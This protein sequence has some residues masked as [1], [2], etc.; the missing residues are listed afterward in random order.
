VEKII[1]EAC[2]K[3][4]IDHNRDVADNQHAYQSPET[5]NEGRDDARKINP[6]FSH[7]EVSFRT[8]RSRNSITSPLDYGS[9]SS[10][11]EAHENPKHSS[12]MRSFSE[13]VGTSH[14]GLKPVSGN[15]VPF[16]LLSTSVK[17]TL[18]GDSEPSAS[19][20]LS[21][22]TSNAA[23]DHSRFPEFV[24]LDCSFVTGFDANASV[25]LFKLRNK[26]ANQELG[27]SVP[28]PI[29]LFFAGE[30]LIY[31]VFIL[32]VLFPTY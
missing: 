3:A 13:A 21:R 9:R 24:V 27:S 25:G 4:T 18:E 26:L 5:A 32:F 11:Y 29:Y 19:R 1:V 10:V 30:V 7:D 8:R 17:E 20:P 14:S 23:D 12:R 6:S 2:E 28:L 15:E 31:Y 16:D 22:H